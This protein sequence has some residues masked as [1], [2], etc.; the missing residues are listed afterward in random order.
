MVGYAD[1]ARGGMPQMTPRPAGVG[2]MPPQPQNA[3]PGTVPAVAPQAGMPMAF[4]GQGAPVAGAFPGQGGPFL[5]AGTVN[6][7]PRA[8]PGQ[9]APVAGAFPGQGG[10]F[11]PQP[12]AQPPQPPPGDAA[13]AVAPMAAMQG[14]FGGFPQQGGFPGQGMPPWLNQQ[15]GQMPWA[16]QAQTS[17]NPMALQQAQ[18]NWL[19]R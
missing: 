5:G 4:P 3:V 11:M 9:G 10:P 19:R 2:Y 15:A 16:R 17:M 8:F 1:V 18:A 13:A 6:G 12:S 7:L 14:R